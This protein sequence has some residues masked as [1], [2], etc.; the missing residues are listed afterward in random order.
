MSL[1]HDNVMVLSPR[2]PVSHPRSWVLSPRSSIPGPW[3]GPECIHF[4]LQCVGH[5]CLFPHFLWYILSLLGW[6]GF[7]HLCVS[8][9]QGPSSLLNHLAG[10]FSCYLVVPVGVGLVDVLAALLGCYYLLLCPKC[11]GEIQAWYIS[12]QHD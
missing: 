2:C 1:G 4:L 7:L 3:S 12:S 6:F 10:S 11:P 5:C 8:R 9:G